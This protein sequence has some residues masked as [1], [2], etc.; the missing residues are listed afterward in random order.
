MSAADKLPIMEREVL[1]DEDT[2]VYNTDDMEFPQLTAPRAET[3]DLSVGEDGEWM[4]S[5]SSSARRTQLVMKYDL[6]ATTVH[7]LTPA[8]SDELQSSNSWPAYRVDVV[9]NGECSYSYR[10][11]NDPSIEGASECAAADGN[12]HCA[13]FCSDRAGHSNVDKHMLGDRDKDYT[14]ATSDGVVKDLQTTRSNDIT[15]AVSV[16]PGITDG[17]CPCENSGADELTCCQ[18]SSKRNVQDYVSTSN[19][20]SASVSTEREHGEDYRESK[21]DH[22]VG[23]LSASEAASDLRYVSS[24]F[25]RLVAEPRFSQTP[26][27]FND[28]DACLESV[29][30]DVSN[31]I[32]PIVS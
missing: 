28:D 16:K 1:G 20:V 13:F 18:M 23:L 29:V 31:D 27:C 9:D 4:T 22:L 21:D 12:F 8:S 7:L 32:M 3:K 24:L 19:G 5:L 11:N 14:S 30:V 17:Y 10:N 2:S 26:L 6:S 15:S 25:V